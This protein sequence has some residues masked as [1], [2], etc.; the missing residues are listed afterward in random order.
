MCYRLGVLC[1]QV[2]SRCETPHLSLEGA[3]VELCSAGSFVNGGSQRCDICIR[4]P[5]CLN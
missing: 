4:H 5:T 1:K 2:R 3:P